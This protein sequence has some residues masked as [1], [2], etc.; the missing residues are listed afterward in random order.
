LNLK[1]KTNLL[2]SSVIIA[3]STNLF[4]I[5]LQHNSLIGLMYWHLFI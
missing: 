3:I 5:F 2:N 1:V 4:S